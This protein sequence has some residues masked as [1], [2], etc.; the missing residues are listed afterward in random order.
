MRGYPGIEPILFKYGVDVSFWG[1]EHHY[2][3]MYPVFNKRVLV[4]DPGTPYTN[5]K[6]PIHFVTGIAGNREWIHDFNDRYYRWSA[7]RTIEFGY[8]TLHI[9]N[10][11]H[12]V[13]EQIAVATNQ[14]PIR[15]SIINSIS[16]RVTANTTEASKDRVIDSITIVQENHGP[17]QENS[18]RN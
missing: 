9:L 3:R 8:T 4:S 14:T 17:F 15:N 6:A 2:E 7:F 13:I 11:T 5:P 10:S 12:A 18:I 1:H 16:T